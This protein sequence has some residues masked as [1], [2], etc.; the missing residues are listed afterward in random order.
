MTSRD[1]VSQAQQT[2]RFPTYLLIRLGELQKY[3]A[4]Y[5]QSTQ[6]VIRFLPYLFMNSKSISFTGSAFYEHTQTVLI[7]L[8]QLYTRF[9]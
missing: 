3:P 2:V 1:D 9:Y 5:F 4:F 6:E 7:Q 8:H